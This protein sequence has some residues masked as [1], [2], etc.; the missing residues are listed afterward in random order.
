MKEGV[1]RRSHNQGGLDLSRE[2]ASHAEEENEEEYF[3]QKRLLADV[4]Q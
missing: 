2:E 3:E 4:T 1:Y